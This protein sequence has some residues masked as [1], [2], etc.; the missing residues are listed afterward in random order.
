MKSSLLNNIDRLPKTKEF[1]NA[2]IDTNKS[3][4]IKKVNW[5]MD[6]LIKPGGGVRWWKVYDKEGLNEMQMCGIKKELI[7]WVEKIK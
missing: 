1:I 3:C 4:Q 6:E 2:V 7:D 5:S